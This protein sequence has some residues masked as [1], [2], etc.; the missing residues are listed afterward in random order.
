[1]AT[2][3]SVQRTRRV[4]DEMVSGPCGNALSGEGAIFGFCVRCASHHSTPDDYPTPRSVEEMAA[5]MRASQR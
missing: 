3:C 1:M 2:T 5:E 4:G